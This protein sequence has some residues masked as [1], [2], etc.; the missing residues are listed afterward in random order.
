MAS[1][2]PMA[3]FFALFIKILPLYMNIGLG[4]V[5]SKALGTTRDSIAR[6]MFFIINPLIIFNGVLNVQLN[7]A[8]LF[9]PVLTFAICSSLCIIFYKL[10]KGWWQDSSRNLMA[11]SAGS[12]NT[13]YFGL[14][15]ALL[16][17]NNEAEGVYVLA[18]LGIVLYENSVGYYI[19]AKG[20]HPPSEC[21]R[22][23]LHLPALYAFFGGL[24]LNL[25][26]MVA[27]DLFS[28]FMAHVK[29]TFTVLGM[30]IIGLGLANLEHFNFDRKFIEL[31][32]LA[33]FLI[34][35]AI[36]LSFNALDSAYFHFYDVTTHKALVLISIVPMAVNTVIVATLLNSQPEKAAS[37]VVL[38]TVFALIYVPLMATFFIL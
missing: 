20:T 24:C 31:T 3:P 2:F 5:A 16:I 14:P 28:N 7:A 35:P 12:G 22:K 38:S 21:A 6:I 18:L 33:K 10:G 25:S 34:W 29:G 17:F 30:M 1:F 19:L 27:P 11:F 37:A 8:V 23:V 9:L 26:G 13:G 32:F 4:F 36:I 15:L